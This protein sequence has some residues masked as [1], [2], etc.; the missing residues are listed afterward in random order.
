M[1]PE[2]LSCLLALIQHRFSYAE[3]VHADR[4]PAVDRDLGQ[5]RAD[6]IGREPV[7]QRAANM[8][9]E[10]LHFPERGDHAEIEDRALARAQ[11]VV[12]PS[13][14]P[15]ILG[16]EPLEIAVEGVG[17][18]EHAIDIV[19]AEHLAAHAEAAV[20]GVLVHGSFLRFAPAGRQAPRAG[21]RLRA[22]ETR[23]RTSPHRPRRWHARRL[24][25][26]TLLL[27]AAPGRRVRTWPPAASARPRARP[28]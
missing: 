24:Q 14:A 19:F 28:P 13:F 27:R 25:A 23:R 8:G 7:A 20:I 17:A 4:D 11:R 10:F 5:H 12:A 16:D 22:G 21:F 2:R 6:L 3:A 15:T 9:L 1:K 18:R 26:M